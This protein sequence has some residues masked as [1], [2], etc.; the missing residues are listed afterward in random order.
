MLAIDMLK[1]RSNFCNQNHYQYLENPAANHTILDTI[2]THPNAS[3]Q[4]EEYKEEAFI[5]KTKS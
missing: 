3:R 4:G 5:S 2:A 1:A